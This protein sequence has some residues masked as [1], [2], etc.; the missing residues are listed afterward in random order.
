MK[1]IV[2]FWKKC[3][4]SKLVYDILLHEYSIQSLVFNNKFVSASKQQRK[5]KKKKNTTLSRNV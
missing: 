3:K 4:S 2:N 1:V 5:R